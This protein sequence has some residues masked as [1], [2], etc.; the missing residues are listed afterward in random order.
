VE[1]IKPVFQLNSNSPPAK[2]E[3]PELKWSKDYVVGS[4]FEGPHSKPPLNIL[5]VWVG[6]V[7]NSG[8][9][10]SAASN[11]RLAIVLPGDLKSRSAELLRPQG[12]SLDAWAGIR[13]GESDPNVFSWK[14]YLP[15]LTARKKI[16]MG[17]QDLGFVAFILRDAPTD[18]LPIGT[19]MVMSFDDAVGK[20]TSVREELAN[21]LKTI[22]YIPGLIR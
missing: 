11:W 8:S 10:P 15:E 6:I 16:A 2:P 17:D 9:V 5:V 1:K 14:N 20:T 4:S 22:P 3:A 21:P 12:Q 18:R 19:K 13:L 7:E